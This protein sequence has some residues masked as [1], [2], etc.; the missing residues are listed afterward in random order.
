MSILNPTTWFKTKALPIQVNP[1]SA[2]ALARHV[3][4]LA[5]LYAATRRDPKRADVKEEIEQRKR[6]IAGYGH[7]APTNEAEARALLE[8]VKE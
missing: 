7:T 5:N 1:G 8:K 3:G 4:R 2:A 6:A